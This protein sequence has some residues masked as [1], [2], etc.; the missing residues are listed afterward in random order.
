MLYILCSLP[1]ACKYNM[2]VRSSP[3]CQLH[4]LSDHH[5]QTLKFLSAHLKTV[6]DSSEKNKVCVQP[7]GIPQLAWL[8]TNLDSFS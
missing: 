1:W 7:V 5:Y 3:L 8:L 6:A 4:E 2:S